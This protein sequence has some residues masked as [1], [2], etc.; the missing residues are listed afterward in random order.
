MGVVLMSNYS[1]ISWAAQYETADF[2]AHDPIQIPKRYTEKRDIEIVAFVTAWL[3]YGN[4][5]AFLTVL[6]KIDIEF[7]RGEPYKYIL[8]GAWNAKK[9]GDINLYR[10]Y[11]REE[12][13][14]L[15]DELQRIYTEHADM[16]AWILSDSKLSLL[17][18]IQKGFKEVKGIPKNA[19]SA[20]KRLNM[21]LRWMIRKNSPVDFGIWETISAE[22]L[23][24]PLDTHVYR[25][26][27]ELGLTQ[28]KTA[29][30]KTVIEITNALKQI[31]PNDPCKG[32][33]ALYGYGVN[34]K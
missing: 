5:K 29:D 9:D 13:Y 17:E 33:F 27:L 7:F 26:A 2:I 1:I 4:R 3:A 25:I 30:M 24:I 10:F 31:F 16:E 8:S 6:D 12:L 23:L 28:R 21:F 32:D 11:K 15:F 22:N 14:K 34:N 18:A 20:C 19:T